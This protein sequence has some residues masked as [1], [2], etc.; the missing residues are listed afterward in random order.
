MKK[1]ALAGAG[2][3]CLGMFAEP[4]AETYK[5]YAKIVGIFDVNRTR[6]SYTA[7]Q[8]DPNVPVYYDFDKMLRE[9]QPDIVIV[10]TV[11]QYHDKYIIKAM[12]Y[13]CDAISEKPIATD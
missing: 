1:Y 10:A 13:G 4:I 11:D 5:D 12:E 7:R 8:T 6:A 2:S 9:T 3:R